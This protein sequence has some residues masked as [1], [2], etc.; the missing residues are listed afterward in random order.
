MKRTLGI[1]VN[2]YILEIVIDSI[3][4]ILHGHYQQDSFVKIY[5]DPENYVYL[6]NASSG[7]QEAIRIL[8]DAFLIFLDDESAFRVI[9]E[10][11]A[12]LYPKAQKCL[13]EILA[14]VLNN[15]DSEVIITTHSPY[16]LSI[17]NNLL[18]ATRVANK[19]PLASEE[20]ESAIPHASWLDPENVNAYFLKNGE[21]ES[22]FDSSIGLIDQN[23][24]DEISEDLGADF[25]ELYHIHS[26]AFA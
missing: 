16:I 26:R 24:L 1:Q 4:Q 17:V 22:I 13:M 20:I 2:S 18:F 14:I 12:H 10:P 7:Q 19:N 25:Q 5:Y 11:E 3:E 21:C 15:T 6:N 23:M 9:E 8:Q